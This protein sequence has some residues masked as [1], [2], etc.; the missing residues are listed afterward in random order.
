MSWEVFYSY[1]W[2]CQKTSKF[3]LA[4]LQATGT[5]G[6]QCISASIST[7]RKFGAGGSQM[8][9]QTLRTRPRPQANNRPTSVKK[10][11]W[12]RQEN[13]LEKAMSQLD[14]S[15][16]YFQGQ[17][18]NFNQD[19]QN[20]QTI[21]PNSTLDFLWPRQ[22][23]RL[24]QPSPPDFL[25]LLRRAKIDAHSDSSAQPLLGTFRCHLN[26]GPVTSGHG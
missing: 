5:N 9:V 14:D 7:A 10:G 24:T 21:Y 16:P 20:Q 15:I 18:G 26:F 13:W 6:C 1:T 19:L 2:T 17:I 4:S 11:P 3:K 25:D 8:K 12:S 22:I 23:S